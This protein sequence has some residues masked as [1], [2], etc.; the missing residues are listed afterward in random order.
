MCAALPFGGIH[1]TAP[2]HPRT[3]PCVAIPVSPDPNVGRTSLPEHNRIGSSAS[4]PRLC[5][6][7]LAIIANMIDFSRDAT[8]SEKSAMSVTPS[9][10]AA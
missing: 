10:E 8:L 4:V 3:A 6:S 9:C 5:Q 2:S 7:Q 1:G